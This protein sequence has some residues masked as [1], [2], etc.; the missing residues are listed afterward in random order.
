MI[1]IALGLSLIILAA[2]CIQLPP[3]FAFIRRVKSA[4]ES[5][6]IR[7]R[8]LKKSPVGVGVRGAHRVYSLLRQQRAF[9]GGTTAL[10]EAPP[11][12]EEE[13]G[14]APKAVCV[15]CLRGRDPFLEECIQGLLQQDYPEYDVLI[16]VDS[17]I[18]PAFEAVHGILAEFPREKRRAGEVWVEVLENIYPQGALK[19]SALIQAARAIR[20][21]NY[22]V[23]ALLDADIVPHPTWLAEL[24][25]PFE[26]PEV[27]VTSGNRWYMPED[28][29]WGS[30]VRYVWN[31]GAVIQM[32]WNQFTWGGSVAL[33]KEVFCDRELSARWRR[34]LSTDTVIYQVAKHHGWKTCFVP[35]VLMVNRE[36]C[37]IRRLFPWITR[38]LLVGKLYHPG[39]PWVIG[40][41][42]GS[43]LLLLAGGLFAFWAFWQGMLLSGF[44]VAG[45]LL[46]YWGGNIWVLR[47]MEQAIQQILCRRGQEARW[48]RPW[49][50]V[51]LVLTMP[52]A[53]FLNAAA[54]IATFFVR[55]V[56]WRGIVYRLEG[57][58]IV[59]EGY[60][61]YSPPVLAQR[62]LSRHSL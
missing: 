56:T 28:A 18:D 49:V 40:H 39:W 62:G 45:A 2:F 5:P 38:Q 47:N 32:F 12:G 61:P 1:P 34:S 57:R 36:T 31:A 11:D 30:L 7:T 53:Q 50:W 16:I 19:G 17:K 25:A 23:V 20:P 14:K 26:N 60:R 21:E 3:I 59:M 43:S 42:L 37:S 54:L 15:L 8:R 51:R 29:S 41:G 6:K 9:S 52:I 10:L 55:S 22:E 44:L 58:R 33:R 46:L 24:V 27:G 48:L 4:A 13:P 35:S